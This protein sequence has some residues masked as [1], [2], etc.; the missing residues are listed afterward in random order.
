MGAEVIRFDMIG[1]RP[2]DTAPRLG[3]HGDEVLATVLGF[4][5]GAIARRHD[6]G[7]CHDD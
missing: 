7:V 3:Q 2:V 4:E 5:S 1:E 6:S